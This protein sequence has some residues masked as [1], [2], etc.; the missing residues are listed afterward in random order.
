MRV[1]LTGVLF[2][3]CDDDGRARRLA[4][5]L[6]G[7][8]QP[9]QVLGVLTHGGQRVN[10]TAARHTGLTSHQVL[11]GHVLGVFKLLE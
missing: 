10:V 9:E 2:L 11:G 7:H 1:P 8:V 3:S 6:Q 5:L 4:E